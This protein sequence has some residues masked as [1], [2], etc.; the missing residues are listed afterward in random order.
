MGL[1]ILSSLLFAP[2]DVFRPSHRVLSLLNQTLFLLLSLAALFLSLTCLPFH[3]HVLSLVLHITAPFFA[4]LY[5]LSELSAH[6][7][8]Q[9]TPLARVVQ[10]IQHNQLAFGT[11]ASVLLSVAVAL[12]LR[13]TDP[14][15]S[16][17]QLMYVGFIG[18]LF[19]R[20]LKCLILPLI[21]SSLVFAVGNMDTRLSG[22]VASQAV[23][24]YLATTVLAIATGIV[25]VVLVQPGKGGGGEEVGHAPVSHNRLTTMDSLFDL[26][27]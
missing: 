7:E 10:A 13:S 9:S 11:L 27:R 1:R 14:L 12:V 20:I 16:P 15:W 21:F 4:S 26:A 2:L 22:R 23:L 5:L 24:Y 18:S 3:A 8:C 17:R 19:L 6:C 25:L